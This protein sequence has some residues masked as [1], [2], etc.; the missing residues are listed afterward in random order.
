VRPQLGPALL[1][2]AARLEREGETIGDI[3][4]LLKRSM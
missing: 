4:P 3:P 2:M 1:E